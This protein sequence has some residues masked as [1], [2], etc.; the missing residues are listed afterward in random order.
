MRLCKIGIRGGVPCVDLKLREFLKKY[1]RTIHVVTYNYSRIVFYRI[2]KKDKKFFLLFGYY[3]QMQG[4]VSLF[5]IL[6]TYE[7]TRARTRFRKNIAIFFYLKSR[8]F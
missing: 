2:I 6:H 4:V 5:N 8:S 3:L 7:E 1:E